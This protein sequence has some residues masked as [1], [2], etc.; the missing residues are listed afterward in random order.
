ME[1]IYLSMRAQVVVRFFMKSPVYKTYLFFDAAIF[2][3]HFPASIVQLPM[4]EN[5]E[6]W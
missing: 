3:N 4:E 5:K 1:T 2:N 6:T